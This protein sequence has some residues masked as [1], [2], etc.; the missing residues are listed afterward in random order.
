MLPQRPRYASQ[1][2][3]RHLLHRLLRLWRL[4]PRPLLQSWPHRLLHRLLQRQ[5][6]CIRPPLQHQRPR[7]LRRRHRQNRLRRRHKRLQHSLL[8]PSHSSRLLRSRVSHC[9]PR[10]R[11]PSSEVRRP[12]NVRLRNRI[13]R[14]R[15]ARPLQLLQRSARVN[16]LGRCLRATAA[17]CR[18][19]IVDRFPR[20]GP[21]ARVR[22]SRCVRSKVVGK[23][24]VVRSHR[25]LEDRGDPAVRRIVLLI[26]DAAR[27]PRE[28]VPVRAC[29]VGQRCCRRCR[30]KCRRRQN[31]VSRF[32][33][34]VHRNVSD[35]SP[36]SARWKGSGSSI[37]PASVQ[38]AIAALQPPLLH[39]RSRAHHATLRLQKELRFASSRKNW[40][41]A[42]KSF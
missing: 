38:A 7:R 12:R 11:P 15:C 9:V 39:R 18:P 23:G 33:R 37:Q 20:I 1:P 19:A 14:R 31:P 42:Q 2:R 21:A 22:A 36:T 41:C 8:P 5:H 26:S 35:L 16:L 27:F 25:V 17:L 30:T 6:R 29:Q 28:H 3:P 10:Q 13:S 40:T 34:A 24:K 4:S 32:T